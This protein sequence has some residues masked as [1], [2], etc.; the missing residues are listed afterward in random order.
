MLPGRVVRITT[1][2]QTVAALS[3]L[4]EVKMGSAQAGFVIGWKIV[5]SSLEGI[6]SIPK[7]KIGCKRLTGSFTSGSGGGTA[8][9]VKNQ[10]GDASHGLATIER[11]NTTQAVVGSGTLEDFDPDVLNESAGAIEAAYLPECMPALGPSE[12]FVLSFEEAP[13]SGT[14][15][16]TLTL[17]I[18]HG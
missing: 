11:N 4:L 15:C 16:A 8:T 6:T 1:G 5:Q 18:T 14:F 3:D 10:S 17:L 7:Y 2:W 12:A 9:V 13:T